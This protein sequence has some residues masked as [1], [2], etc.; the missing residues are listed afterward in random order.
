MEGYRGVGRGQKSRDGCSVYRVTESK[1]L[2]VAV[3]A[4]EICGLGQLDPKT[5]V[6]EAMRLL[7]ANSA[8]ESSL[9][10]SCFQP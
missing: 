3:D 9:Q 10:V 8:F 6:V 7:R 1:I 2:L 5:S 4:G